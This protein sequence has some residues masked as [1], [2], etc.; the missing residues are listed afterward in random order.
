MKYGADPRA[1]AALH[2]VFPDLEAYS[3]FKR[4]CRDMKKESTVSTI[5]EFARRHGL[6]AEAEEKQLVEFIEKGGPFEGCGEDERMS[7]D[8]FLKDLPVRADTQVQGVRSLVGNIN[9]FLAAEQIGIDKLDESGSIFVKIKNGGIDTPRRREAIRCVAFYL[10]YRKYDKPDALRRCNYRSLMAFCNVEPPRKRKRENAREGVRVL[11][12]IYA[13][14]KLIDL[15]TV[16]ELCSGMENI[17]DGKDCAMDTYDVTTYIVDFPLRTEPQMETA[18][19]FSYGKCINDAF[20]FAYQL[21]IGW[22]LS[23]HFGF[24]RLLSIGID[25]GGFTRNMNMRLE[26]IIRAKIQHDPVIRMTDF[27]RQCVLTNDLKVVLWNEPFQLELPAMGLLNIWG[28]ETFFSVVYEDFCPVMLSDET[29][30]HSIKDI[31]QL[32]VW[33]RRPED[34]RQKKAKSAIVSFFKNAR[35]SFLGLEIAKVLFYRK[36]FFE[37]NEILRII[38]SLHPRNLAARTL[39]VMI[40]WHMGV[41]EISYAAAKIHFERS[42][43]EARFVIETVEEKT[44]EFYCEWA[45]GIVGHACF[46]ARCIRSGEAPPPRIRTRQGGGIARVGQKSAF[47]RH[48]GFPDR[49]SLH[50]LADLRL[51]HAESF[52]RQSRIIRQCRRWFAVSGFQGREGNVLKN[53]GKNLP[54][55][56]M[57]EK[58][59]YERGIAQVS[60]S[61]R[62]SGLRR[63]GVLAGVQAQLAVRVCSVLL[64]FQSRRHGRH[65]QTG[66]GMAGQSEKNAGSTGGTFPSPLHMHPV[67]RGTHSSRG[68][69]SLH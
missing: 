38:L 29:I 52:E 35:N 64:G 9:Q 61:K 27:A 19:P 66:P 1:E 20:S 8:A 55:G 22:M 25:A 13:R 18:H 36:Q 15:D 34:V 30:P 4:D 5:L 63:V 39:R 11:V 48:N 3:E 46:I 62:H 51:R 43:D 49:L 6:I 32:L 60:F 24:C 45:L 69:R 40:Y 56:G 26:A 10:G 33:F 42:E 59:L 17:L 50:V 57:D 31:Q 47:A 2:S 12:N 14:G 65:R 7:F 54:V 41:E 67:L 28:V 37:A 68:L 44:E 21:M 23:D 53:R 58:K 16:G